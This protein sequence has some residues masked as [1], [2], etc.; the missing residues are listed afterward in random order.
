MRFSIN[1]SGETSVVAFGH[2]RRENSATRARPK[3]HMYTHRT[4]RW[5][6]INLCVHR[7]RSNRIADGRLFF[8]NIASGQTPQGVNVESDEELVVIALLLDEEE[9]EEKT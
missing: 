5:K 4:N 1:F 6:R 8:S 3:V 2:V 9:N 7:V